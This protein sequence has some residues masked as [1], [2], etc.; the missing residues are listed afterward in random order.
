M[1]K[2]QIFHRLFFEDFVPK[3]HGYQW[4]SNIGQFLTISLCH[5]DHRF[6]EEIPECYEDTTP[7][8]RSEER[9]EDKWEHPHTK[10]TSRNRDEMSHDGNQSP[11]ECIESII[12]EEEF[13]CLLILLLGD[14]DI[15]SIF[16]EKWLPEPSPEDPIIQKGSRNRPE[17]SDKNRKIRIQSSTSCEYSCRYH[18]EF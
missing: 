17:S 16:L 4:N 8:S 1:D 3:I 9:D 11:D 6:S 5:F 18:H 2:N 13:L 14:E 7:E 10:D 15:F 12:L